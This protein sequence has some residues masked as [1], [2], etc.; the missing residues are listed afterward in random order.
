V[1]PKSL[2]LVALLL[3]SFCFVILGHG[4]PAAATKWKPVDPAELALTASTIQHDANAEILEWDMR[5][6]D[7]VDVKPPNVVSEQYLRVKIYNGAGRDQQSN[8]ELPCSDRVIVTDIEARTIKKDGTTVELKKGD[9]FMRDV[10]K[11]GGVKLKAMT[12]ALPQVEAGAIVEYHWRQ[13]ER[14]ASIMFLPLF[15]QHEIPARLISTHIKPRLGMRVQSYN[16]AWESREVEKDGFYLLRATNMPAV[17]YEPHSPPQMQVAPWTLVYYEPD[18]VST[19]P[20]TYWK[21]YGRRVAR[22][23]KDVV[24]VTGAVKEAAELATRGATSVAEKVQRIVS[25]CHREIVRM[26]AGTD[27]ARPKKFKPNTDAADTLAQKAGYGMD[28]VHLATAMARA[29]GLDA[30]IAAVPSR[31]EMSGQRTYVQSFLRRFRLVAVRDGSQWQFVDPANTY[32]ADGRL[33]WSFEGQEAIISDE[34]EPLFVT[35]P[36]APPEYS[37]RKVSVKA[38]LEEDGT[39]QAD[40]TIQYS[41]QWGCARKDSEDAGTPE[42]RQKDLTEALTKAWAGAEITS[43]HVEN[44]TDQV[45]P[46]TQS[47]H[48]RFPLYAQHAGSRLVFQP[49]IVERGS[50]PRFTADTRLNDVAFD[51]PWTETETVTVEA[52]PGFTFE[53]S[54]PVPEARLFDAGAYHMQVGRDESGRLVMNRTF[55]MGRNGR[56]RFPAANYYAVKV[57]FDVVSKA[58]SLTVSLKKTTGQ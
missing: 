17:K 33:R 30:R 10:V 35:T 27:A 52:P 8:V 26:D 23:Y 40:V 15:F 43:V 11:T 6:Y 57:F 49:A 42:Q 47:Y 50:L 14:G 18:G 44:V 24:K 20:D 2:P 34:T 58:D 45:K 25:Y 38:K 9:I 7:D 29:V 55:T 32:E 46:Y 5:I 53:D 3:S 41:G 16:M 12:F 4:N 56:L 19:D 36:I 54:D 21:D 39:L 1:N 51:Y 37:S 48:A 28:V 13:V 31:T 22:S